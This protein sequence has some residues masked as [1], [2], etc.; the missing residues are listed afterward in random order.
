MQDY[1]EAIGLCAGAF[2]TFSN[3]PQLIK[4]VRTKSIKDLSLITYIVNTF[5]LALWITYGVMKQS[6]S[7]IGANTITLCFVAIILAIKLTH[8]D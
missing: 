8:P 7:M 4:A 1:A 5:G 6:P 2:T 3:L